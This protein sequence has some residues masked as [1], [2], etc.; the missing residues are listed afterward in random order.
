VAEL[1]R[2]SGER[3]GGVEGVAPVP[4]VVTLEGG[5]R[6]VASPMPHARSVSISI[7]IAAGARYEA[8]PEDAGLSHFVEHLCFKGTERRPSPRDVAAEIDAVGGSINAAT[9][10]ELTVYYAKVTPDH[11]EQAL[12]VLAD[13][14]RHS[15]FRDEEIERERGV[16][17]EELAA[18]EDAPDEQVSIALDGLLWPDQ[19]LGRDVAGTPASV[20]GIEAER[21]RAYY[22]E[23]YVASA[24]VVA[25]AGA[26]DPARTYELVRSAVDGWAQGAPVDWLR[27]RREPRGEQ[28]RLLTKDTEQAHI[29]LGMRGLDARDEDRYALGLL[30]IVLGEGMS[31]RLFMRLREELGLCYDVHSAASY[32]RDAGTFA[33]HAGV[34]PGNA[35]ATVAEIVRELARA[36]ASV[37]AE[38]LAR[39]KQ[40][41]RSRIQLHMEDSRAVSGW[42]GTRVALDLPLRDAEEAIACF[43]RVTLEDVERVAHRLIV[44]NELHLAVVGPL[45]Q[46]EQLEAQ[47]R[48]R[49]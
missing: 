36:R 38:E 33:V 23:Q 1:G 10:R 39:A 22:H 48:L 4:E 49:D 14:V 17:L 7:Y 5:L 11:A 18:V 8:A 43:D 16:I 42:Y 34:D 9:D 2:A 35:E 47:L 13:A 32:L 24:A 31:S 40:L 19:P 29:S 3:G 15:L 20:G 41:V 26:V 37:T 21:L 27:A 12:D 6:V 28:V 46:R 44:E 30:S 25:V 45:D